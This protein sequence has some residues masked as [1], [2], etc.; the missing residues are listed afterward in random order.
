MP[1]GPNFHAT[2]GL[3]LP[4][5][6]FPSV[7]IILMTIWYINE[8][9]FCAS[10]SNYWLIFFRSWGSS[11]QSVGCHRWR[12][13]VQLCLSQYSTCIVSCNLHTWHSIYI[14]HLTHNMYC[15]FNTQSTYIVHSIAQSRVCAEKLSISTVWLCISQKTW[16]YTHIV[17]E[18]AQNIVKVDRTK[19]HGALQLK[20]V[21]QDG[22]VIQYWY[23][24]TVSV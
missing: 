20:L 21:L 13:T 10:I 2:T 8:R 15:A 9:I 5:E 6:C 4:P 17:F 12:S 24:T 3:H 23:S 14:A 1:A 19:S 11:C 18:T 22:T 7:S 16:H